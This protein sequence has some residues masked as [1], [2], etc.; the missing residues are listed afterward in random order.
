MLGE[1]KAQCRQNESIEPL[2]S[3]SQHRT[4]VWRCWFLCQVCNYVSKFI[5]ILE[6]AASR[7]A[8]RNYGL[9]SSTTLFYNYLILSRSPKIWHRIGIIL[10][11]SFTVKYFVM[12]LT[13]I[14]FPLCSLRIN[15]IQSHDP[16]AQHFYLKQWRSQTSRPSVNAT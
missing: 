16:L 12:M 6:A 2:S 1:T 15:K 3:T 9:L 8:A 5:K 14:T 13:I 10:A 4:Q 11:K 7:S